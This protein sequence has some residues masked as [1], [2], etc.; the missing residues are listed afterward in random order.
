MADVRLPDFVIVGSPRCG[1]TTVFHHLRSHPQISMPAVK[2]IEFFDTHWERGVPW[3][4]SHFAPEADGVVAGEASPLYL[5]NPEAMGRLH[6]VLPNAQLLAVFRNPIDAC[7]SL[8]HYRRA[9]NMD[10]GSFDDALEREL[11]GNGAGFP[12][13]DTYSY[14]LQLD[15]LEKEHG[16]KV[17]V[18][19]YDELV[20]DPEKFFDGIS[21]ALGVGSLGLDGPARVVNSAD[22]FRSVHLRLLTKRAPAPIRRII[23][24]VNRVADVYPPVSSTARTLVLG[25]LEDSMASLE[26]RTG[27]DLSH[28]RME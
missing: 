10:S 21:T 11:A 13:I 16:R 18:F 25:K 28:W 12:Y 14:G 5:S 1:T 9:R 24:R 6:G 15:H 2:E 22:R 27:R 20:E 4:A 19:W 23:G 7:H 8:F 26:R 17:R 3:Y